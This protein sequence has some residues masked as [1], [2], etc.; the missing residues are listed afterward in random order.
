MPTHVGEFEI[1]RVSPHFLALRTAVRPFNEGPVIGVSGG[2]DSTAL[3]AAAVAEGKRPTAVCVNHNLQEGS[4]EVAERAAETCRR[5]GTEATVVDV[6]VPGGNLEANARAARYRALAGFGNEVWVAHTLDDQAETYLLGALRGNPT[7]ML[8][9]SAVVRPLLGVRRADTEGACR[10]LGVSTWHDPQNDDESFRRV[11]IRRRVLPLLSEIAGA[12]AAVPLARAAARA[13]SDA[14][15]LDATCGSLDVD[16][17]H[18]AILHRQVVRFLRE[19]G[20][21]VNATTIAA[22]SSMVTD[23][24]GQGPAHVGSG[25]LVWREGNELHIG[26]AD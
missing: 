13:A 4:R 3:L 16:T 2:P 1:P 22:V 26:A 5:L 8:V 18:P 24:H 21:S 20:A 10:E 17:R 7:G 19:H 14:E 11:A 6:A 23:W 25:L 9:E 15:Y 12:D